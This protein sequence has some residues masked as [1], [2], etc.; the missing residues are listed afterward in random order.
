MTLSC[1]QVRASE[2]LTLCLTFCK[3]WQMLDSQPPFC[4]DHLVLVYC[5]AFVFINDIV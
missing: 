2:D 1:S 5:K 3:C 4:L